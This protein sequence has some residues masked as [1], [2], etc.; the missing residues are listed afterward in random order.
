MRQIILDVETT[1]LEIEQGNRIIEIGCVEMVNRRLTGN[2]FHRFV[3]P[4]RD[5]EAGA[6]A[7][8]GI[9]TE[10][11]ADKPRFAEIAQDLVEYLR[12]AELIIHNAD[13]DTGFLNAE[14]SRL[15]GLPTVSSLCSVT[16]TLAMARRL[17]PGQKNN[18]DAL[19]RR[20]NVDNTRRDNHGALLDAQLLAEVYL[21]MTG[22]QTRILLED[23]GREATAA[24]GNLQRL[25]ATQRPVILRATEAELAAHAA[26][27][28]V[29]DQASKG[30]SLWPKENEPTLSPA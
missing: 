29:I 16:D 26:R 6:L 25:L 13:F 27:L 19:C 10:Q 17:H 21:G 18:L 20:Y 5:S 14:F 28:Q 7:V 22:G 1:G 8:H 11:L 4:D 12:G 2:D 3:N 15:D 23:I 24:S 9:T 30:A